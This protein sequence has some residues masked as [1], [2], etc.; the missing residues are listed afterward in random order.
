MGLQNAS[1]DQ[2]ISIPNISHAYHFSKFDIEIKDKK[3]TENIATDHLSRIENYETSD[4]NKVDDNFPG[5]TLM[6]ITTNDTPWFTDIENYLVWKSVGYGVSK[7]WIRRIGDFLKHR[8]IV[9]S[10]MDMAYWSL[11]Q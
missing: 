10:L 6:E 7:C 1:S 3:G 4:D 11:E 8:Y 9:S 2:C 5:E